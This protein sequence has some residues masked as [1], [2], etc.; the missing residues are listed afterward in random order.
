MIILCLNVF[1]FL[2]LSRLI[3][4]VACC[5]LL[6]VEAKDAEMKAVLDKK[7]KAIEAMR[8]KMKDQEK[9]KQSEIIKLQM[10]VLFI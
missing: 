6:Q 5:V 1:V 10:E 2:S 7:E 8:L 3:I 4:D 9:A